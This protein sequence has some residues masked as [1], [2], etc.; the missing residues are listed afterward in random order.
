M[1]EFVEEAHLDRASAAAGPCPTAPLK[2][3]QNGMRDGVLSPSRVSQNESSSSCRRRAPCRRTTKTIASSPKYRLGTPPARRFHHRRIRLENLVDRT[4]RGV[5]ATVND[6]FLAAAHDNPNKVAR[7]AGF[8][9]S[10]RPSGPN[11]DQ[12]PSSWLAGKSGMNRLHNATAQK[13]NWVDRD[14]RDWARARSSQ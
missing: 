2:L 11:A 8:T 3:L 1:L 6:H 9:L 7:I 10:A 13:A 5:D 12:A 4:R 14:W